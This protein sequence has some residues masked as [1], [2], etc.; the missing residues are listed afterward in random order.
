MGTTPPRNPIWSPSF[1]SPS[2]FSA[3]PTFGTS[4]LTVTFSDLSPGSP[5]QWS[6]TFG[7][8]GA[9]TAQNPS[10]VYSSSGNYDVSLTVVNAQ[11]NA[12]STRAQYISVC[13]TADY[14]PSAYGTCS[15]ANPIVGGSLSSLTADDGVTMDIGSSS[16]FG[17]RTMFTVTTAYTPTQVAGIDF[18]VKVKA[19]P[20][21]ARDPS[22]DLWSTA[23]NTSCLGMISMANPIPTDLHLLSTPPLRDR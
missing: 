9:S 14:Y 13:S 5:T 10:H 20:N 22:M 4:P 19:S 6:W 15:G 18:D 1:P 8:G 21:D 3:T 2:S 12:T 11:G 16:T 7:D 17:Y 23:G